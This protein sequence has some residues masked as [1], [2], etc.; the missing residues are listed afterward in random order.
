MEPEVLSSVCARWSVVLAK[1]LQRYLV[2]HAEGLSYE[3]N[4]PEE[5]NLFRF[6]SG[7]ISFVWRCYPL[8]GLSAW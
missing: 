2:F 3:V 5:V 6:P 1:T 7:G 8:E 4:P